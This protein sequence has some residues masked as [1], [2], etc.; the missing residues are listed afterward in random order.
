MALF[1]IQSGL[2]YRLTDTEGDT[3]VYYM[4]LRGRYEPMSVKDFLV[5]ENL[6]NSSMEYELVKL[7]PF[8][9]REY[10]GHAFS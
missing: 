1:L 9:N 3:M 10:S 4:S 5:A 6:Y 8:D 2:D 7:R